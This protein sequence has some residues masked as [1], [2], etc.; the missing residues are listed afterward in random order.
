M[1]CAKDSDYEIIMA[2]IQALRRNRHPCVIDIHDAF[3]VR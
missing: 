1:F 2:E 3:Q